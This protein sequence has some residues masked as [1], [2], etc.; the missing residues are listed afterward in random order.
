MEVCSYAS[1]IN[2]RERVWSDSLVCVVELEGEGYAFVAVRE[3][4]V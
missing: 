2:A 4:V 3:D 1:M